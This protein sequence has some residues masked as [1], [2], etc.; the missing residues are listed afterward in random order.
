M[1]EL[2]MVQMLSAD[3][4]HPR[5][6]NFNWQWIHIYQIMSLKVLKFIFL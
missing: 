3:L 5:D 4:P 2:K 6:A 1:F